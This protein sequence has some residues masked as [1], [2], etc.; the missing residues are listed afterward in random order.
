[1][2]FQLIMAFKKLE[3]NFYCFD[4]RRNIH[5]VYAGSLKSGNYDLDE[6]SGVSRRADEANDSSLEASNILKELELAMGI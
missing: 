3:L 5:F 4:S 6:A 1:M 2:V